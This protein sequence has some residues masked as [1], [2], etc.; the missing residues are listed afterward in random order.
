ML[1][2]LAVVFAESPREETIHRQLSLR[3]GVTCAELGTADEE[4]RDILLSQTAPTQMPQSVPIR[5]TDCLVRLFGQDDLVLANMQAW[6]VDSSRAGEAL[7]VLEALDQLPTEWRSALTLAALSH[8]DAR[9]RERFQTRLL[10]SQTPAVLE[11]VKQA[12]KE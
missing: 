7:V 12:T 5:A 10:Q 8:P 11:I 6:I 3:D 9:W 4:L 2:I 1:A